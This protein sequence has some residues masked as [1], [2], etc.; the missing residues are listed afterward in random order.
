MKTPFFVFKLLRCSVDATGGEFFSS[1]QKSPVV[2]DH[3]YGR[4]GKPP[5]N[6]A[7]SWMNFLRTTLSRERRTKH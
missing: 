2:R 7:L 4:Q 3:S 6:I 1:K 5:C